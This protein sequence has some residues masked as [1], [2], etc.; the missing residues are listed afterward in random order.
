MPTENNK[1]V[2]LDQ[3]KKALA[4]SKAEADKAIS[5]SGGGEVATDAEVDALIE[6]Y[7]TIGPREVMIY[8]IDRPTPET[9]LRRIPRP[10]LDAIADRIRRA[11]GIP[12]QVSG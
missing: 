10:E 4:R 12:V 8:T 2:T 9:T 7:R 5:A 1:K 6:A 3:M 11:T